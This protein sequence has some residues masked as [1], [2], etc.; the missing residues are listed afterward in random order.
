MTLTMI[1][2]YTYNLNQLD[3]SYIFSKQL[4]RSHPMELARRDVE[5]KLQLHGFG[6]GNHL[7]ELID[8]IHICIHNTHNVHIVDKVKT[9]NT[10]PCDF[11]IFVLTVIALFCLRHFAPWMQDQSDCTRYLESLNPLDEYTDVLSV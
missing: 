3:F 4:E 9:W 6:A 7:W 8:S 10:K 2:K 11:V 5:G 1:R